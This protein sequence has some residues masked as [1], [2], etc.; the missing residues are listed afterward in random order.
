M[1][2]YNSPRVTHDID[3]AIRTLDVDRVIR[4]MYQHEYV[5]VSAVYEQHIQ[6][7]TNAAAAS[8]WAERNK[9]GSLSFISRP[10]SPLPSTGKTSPSIPFDQVDVSSQVDFLFELC[11]PV[12]RLL[13]RA[14]RIDLPGLSFAVADIHDLIQLK[15]TRTD[16]SSV[17]DQDI[18]Y[19]QNLLKQTD[20]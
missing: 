6:I 5:L 8:R 18:R 12:T 2:L 9:S 11:L 17:D 1:R 20:E 10:P 4:L 7:V 19:L 15:Q 16:R 14:R 3:I 13:Q